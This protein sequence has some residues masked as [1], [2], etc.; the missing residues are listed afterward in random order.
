MSVITQ[1]TEW[2][3]NRS[4]TAVLEFGSSRLRLCSGKFIDN[5]FT[6]EAFKQ[7]ST[8]A[9]VFSSQLGQFVFDRNE[10]VKALKDLGGYRFPLEKYVSVIIPDQAFHFG[11]FQVPAIAAKTGLQPFLEREIQK[12]TSLSYKDYTVKYEFGEKKDNK[13]PVHFCA[14]ANGILSEIHSV[15]EESGLVPLSFQP[16][17]AGIVKL[18]RQNTPESKHPSVMLHF[19]NETITAGIYGHEGLRAIHLLNRGVSDLLG[20]IEKT[21]NVSHE[22]AERMLTSEL[23]LLE[24][25]NSDA[26]AEIETYQILEPTLI[27]ILQ[28]IYGFLL[29]FSN[30]HP[31]ESGF[32][33]IV[34][35]G[36]GSAI[37]NIDKLISANLGIPAVYINQEIEAAVAELT[38][39]A[40]ETTAT[41]AAVLGN[42]HL[43]PWKLDRYDRIMAA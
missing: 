38:L 14:L 3:L 32:V 17:F 6:I 21:R 31:D 37:R 26:Q 10:M 23:V 41:L 34:I 7:A 36:G 5:R 24:D 42:L 28:K 1:I 40:G 18:L 13:I 20:S 16:S 11:S 22:D 33:K 27:D 12:T 39:P 2:L 4:Q 9:S 8:P 29:L 43:E 19:G 30:D 15:C 35:S 25:P